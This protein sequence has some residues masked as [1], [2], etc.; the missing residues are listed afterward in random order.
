MNSLATKLQEAAKVATQTL[1]AQHH[2][3]ADL[4]EHLRLMQDVQDENRL[5]VCI[6]VPGSKACLLFPEE[7]EGHPQEKLQELEVAYWA[8]KLIGYVNAAV[9]A[10]L[11]PLATQTQGI[12]NDA[13]I[14]Q[15]PVQSQP[16]HLADKEREGTTA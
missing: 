15:E 13:P 16:Y 14:V 2:P 4:M 9:A 5:F 8:D 11:L 1:R 10:G 12:A 3:H 6:P 7:D